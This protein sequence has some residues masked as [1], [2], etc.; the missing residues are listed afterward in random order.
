MANQI[1]AQILSRPADF[2]GVGDYLFHRRQYPIA[3]FFIDDQRRQ[4][5]DDVHTV[6]DDLA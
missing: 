3:V 6:A 1:L 5:F 4:E 2:L